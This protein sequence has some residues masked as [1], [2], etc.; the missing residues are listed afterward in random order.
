M[1]EMHKYHTS[2]RLENLF[3]YW[4][5]HVFFMGDRTEGKSGKSFA[6]SNKISIFLFVIF[7]CVF[8]RCVLEWDILLVI[9][10]ETHFD[11]QYFYITKSLC[12]RLIFDMVVNLYLHLPTLFLLNEVHIVHD[13]YIIISISF[14]IE[15]HYS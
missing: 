12:A 3:V 15:A 10:S 14:L 11:I 1:H 2:S 7:L 5:G 9:G 8:L 4:Q 13:I 6:C